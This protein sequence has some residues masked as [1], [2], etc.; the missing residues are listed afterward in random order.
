MN[1]AGPYCIILRR[2]IETVPHA[3]PMTMFKVDKHWHHAIEYGFNGSQV[4]CVFLRVACFDLTQLL[5]R[6]AGGRTTCGA[7]EQPLQQR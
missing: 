5:V 6:C 7:A 2:R 4:C 1:A 3:F